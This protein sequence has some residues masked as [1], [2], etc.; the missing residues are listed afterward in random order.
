M[1]GTIVL[2]NFTLKNWAARPK[3]TISASPANI[4]VGGS[5][6]LTWTSTGATSASI[7]NKIGAVPVNGS[8]V[9]TPTKTTKYTITVKNGSGSAMAN[10]TVT[11]TTAPPAATF[12]AV[13]ATISPG[14]SATLSWTSSGATSVFINQG[15]GTVALNGS[16]I[17]T[18]GQSIIYTLTAK[19]TGGT[20]TRQAAITVA[21]PP[22]VSF[23]AAPM[24][25]KPGESATLVWTSTEATSAAIDNGVGAMPVIGSIQVTPAQNTM[26]TITVS[27]LGG[28]ASAQTAVYMSNGKT[29]YAYVPDSSA[30]NVAVIDTASNSVIKTIPTQGGPMGVALSQDGTR[31][32]VSSIYG[33]YK[34]F[35]TLDTAANVV[36]CEKSS[37]Y[38]H[39]GAQFLAVDA[40]REYL[41]GASIQCFWDSAGYQNVSAFYVFNMIHNEQIKCLLIPGNNQ[42]GMVLHPVGTRLYL[43]KPDENAILCLDTTKLQRPRAPG[44]TYEY[45]SDEATATIV[46]NTPRSLAISLDGHRLYASGADGIVVLDTNSNSILDTIAVSGGSLNVLAMHPDGNRLYAASS[47]ILQA[48]DTVTNAVTKTL[49]M[50][51]SDT[52]MN[53]H[54]DGS[55]IYL[56]NRLN[57]TVSVVDASNLTLMA[58]IPIAGSPYANGNFVGYISESIAGK[59]TQDG[60]GLDGV[61]VAIA[62]A[63]RNEA[64]IT[65]SCGNY[66]TAV[67]KGTYAVAPE[68]IGYAFSPDQRQ[69]VVEQAVSGCDFIAAL[70][71]PTVTI[72][73]QPT[74][75]R[76][77]QPTTITWSSTNATSAVLDNGTG[78]SYC[79][80]NG[81]DSKYISKTTTFAVTVT[82]PGGTATATVVV[83]FD[84]STT[85]TVSIAANPAAIN[86]GESSTL[87]WQSYFAT[88]AQIDNGIGNVAVNGSKVVTPAV[89]TTYKITVTG[90][91]GLTETATAAVVVAG[92]VPSVVISAS[93]ATIVEGG[94]STLT[95]T[96]TNA[97]LASI[98]NGIGA[99]PVNGLVNVSPT[100][101]TTYI[102]TA[103]G[104]GG[105]NSASVKVNVEKAPPTVTFSAAPEFIPP[106]GSSTLTWT[107]KDATSVS[108]DQGIGVVDL[109]GSLVVS[110][111]VE[112]IY[113]LTAIGPG[114]TA[115]ASATVKL[116]A[117]HLNSV[118]NGMKMAMLA[119]NINQ[120]AAQFSDQTRDKYSQIFTAIADQLP[121]IA[122]EMR[123]I[124]PVYFEEYGAK[125]R[126]KRTEEIEGVS[127][128]ITYY[129]YF[130]QDED[131]SWKILNY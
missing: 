91:G 25:I 75:V 110:P 129:I 130:V 51:N 59:V 11:V 106:G 9:V 61:N 17:V 37:Q 18:P 39:V 124:E 131:G 34:K 128:D 86:P 58:T 3:V 122:Q 35:L 65:D 80:V 127:Y 103:T 107:T 99:V 102:L 32:F 56:T 89:T 95:W 45:L 1:V 72:S 21:A 112:T 52:G 125:F 83:T 8:V 38:I 123:D 46:V 73:A 33:A 26:Y 55:R 4:V 108:I 10:A 121:Q 29:C 2:L 98:D 76:K 48:I 117:T 7:N 120:A 101:M 78:P 71:A 114:G 14:G 13:P 119:G 109:N 47:D 67:K 100:A 24:S 115:M 30:N 68:K 49:A 69:V 87:T 41:Y 64:V 15:I 118:W 44:A 54:P 19:G 74:T 105:S 5:S 85:P 43:S 16:R 53:V 31:V 60:V 6:T 62:S 12:I 126:I 97:D 79:P 50:E 96:T 116:L 57:N 88:S 82:G 22:T 94:S 63:E 70:Q 20:T 113:T 42:G 28:T 84:G 104:P 40:A 23:S 111:T 77:G 93:P 66:I 92:S 27:G 81:S 36:I 90:A